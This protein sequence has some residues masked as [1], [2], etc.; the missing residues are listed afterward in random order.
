MGI[1]S[2]LGALMLAGASASALAQ[3]APT[4]LPASSD[5]LPRWRPSG[6][7]LWDIQFNSPDPLASPARVIDLDGF[8]TPAE[9]VAA[10]KKQ[11]RKVICYLNVGAWEDWR[12][13]RDAFPPR[14]LG[15]DYEGW[16]GERWLDIRDIDALAPILRARL[17]LCAAKGFHAVDPDNIDLYQQETGF[18]ITRDD[19]VR[20]LRWL[21]AEAHVRGL[22][23]GQKNAGDLVPDLV[24]LYDF[25]LIESPFRAGFHRLF[26]PYVTARKTVLAIEYPFEGDPL[27]RAQTCRRARSAGFALIYKKR[28]L[29]PW[30][31]RCP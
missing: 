18:A 11:G 2:W 20:F 8:D 24:D 27:D 29:D 15:S 13:D 19:Q 26:R 25:A 30:V 12:P 6:T 14:V 23:I 1:R 17:D 7:P 4:P 10:L 22:A 28:E 21:A 16:P 9:T 3:P 5:P 31:D